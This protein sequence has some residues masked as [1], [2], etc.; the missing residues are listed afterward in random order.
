VHV[1]SLEDP[2]DGFTRAEPDLEDVFFSHI[3][4]L[5]EAWAE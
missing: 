5:H 3:Q 1:Y 2:G 4:G